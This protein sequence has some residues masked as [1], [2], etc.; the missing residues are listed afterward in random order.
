MLTGIRSLARV[1][2]NRNEF[3]HNMSEELCFHIEQYTQ[4]N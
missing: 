1:L 3:E 2:R 4:T